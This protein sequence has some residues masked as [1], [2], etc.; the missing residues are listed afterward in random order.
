MSSDFSNTN[1]TIKRLK[2]QIEDLTETQIEEMKRATYTG[3]S[4]E[5]AKKYDARR[6]RINELTSQVTQL[7]QSVSDNL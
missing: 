1:A 2:Q 3:M 6:K 5:Q 7:Q 4:S